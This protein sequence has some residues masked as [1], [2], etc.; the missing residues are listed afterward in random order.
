M[1]GRS[2][3]PLLRRSGAWP[4]GRGLL[5]EYRVGDAGRYATCEFAGI[6]TRDNLYVRHSR[7]VDPSTSQ[8]IPA[9]ER[10]RYD[11]KQDPFELR[12]QCFGGSSDNCPLSEK[13]LD[14]EIRLSQLRDC[15][16]I[17]G[18]DDHVGGRPFCE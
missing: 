14:L 3:M 11:L 15:A 9:D 5:T 2:L 17:A 12:N 10:E 18:R 4:H 7:V 1:D 16:G 13:Q 6:R 8:C